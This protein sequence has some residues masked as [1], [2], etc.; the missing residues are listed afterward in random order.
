MYLFRLSLLVL[1]F[2]CGF[3][4]V[5]SKTPIRH[6]QPSNFKKMMRHTQ[7]NVTKSPIYTISKKY[8]YYGIFALWILYIQSPEKM[9]SWPA[10][11]QWIRTQMGGVANKAK[12]DVP[13]KD[14]IDTT[15]SV[16]V[17]SNQPVNQVYEEL[18]NKVDTLHIK[19]N[20]VLENTDKTKYDPGYVSNFFKSLKPYV[21]LDVETPFKVSPCL[22]ADKIKK[23]LK[24]ILAWLGASYDTWLDDGE[25]EEEENHDHCH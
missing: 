6:Q 20:Q 13:Q 14:Q 1:I 5:L 16:D 18:E 24:S 19:V 7:Q 9:V 11:L 2:S 3:Q 4:D 23:D 25:D 15:G 8:W 17:K 10:F 22:F 12:Y 21:K